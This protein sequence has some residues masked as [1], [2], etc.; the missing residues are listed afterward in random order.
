[1]RVV[2]GRLR[3]RVIAAPK[4]DAIRPTADRLREALFNILTHAYADPVTGVDHPAMHEPR[5]L[6][7]WSEGQVW[8]SPEWQGRSIGI[9][10]AQIDHLPLEMK[11]L[12]PTQRRTLEDMQVS[13]G[14][15]LLYAVNPDS[16]Q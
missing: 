5:E 8:C 7:M 4:S 9:M 2:G 14:S 12:R 1:M 6:P 15:L 3:S 13:G 10:K 11:G 16:I